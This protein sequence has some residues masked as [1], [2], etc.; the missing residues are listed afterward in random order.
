MFNLIFLLL[1]RKKEEKNCAKANKIYNFLFLA[2]MF[3]QMKIISYYMRNTQS[4]RLH[5]MNKRFKCHQPGP[6]I[7]LVGTLDSMAQIHAFMFMRRINR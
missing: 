3:P 4:I 6:S 2:K 1:A 7:P 5:C